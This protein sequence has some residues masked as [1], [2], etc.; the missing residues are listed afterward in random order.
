MKKLEVKTQEEFDKLPNKFDKYTQIS[1]I[2]KLE[3]ISKVFKNAFITIHDNAVIK[4]V[5]GN[6]VI[7]YVSGNAVIKSVS[8]NA[9]IKVFSSQVNIKKARQFAIIICQDCSIVQIEDKD[10]T[11]LLHKVITAPFSLEEFIN[12]Y[13]VKSKNNKLI[14]YK[15]VNSRYRDFYTGTI[16]YKIGKIIKALDWD[17]N[18]SRECGGGL[19][20]SPS[21][22]FCKKFNSGL[23][24]ECEVDIKDI[25]VCPN[26]R[27]PYKIR[28]KKLK[29]LRE[30]FE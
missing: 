9:V 16:K 6:A 25:V 24:L 17:K 7:E 18:E 14:L 27:F 30:V 2:G 5:S 4:S 11:V 20:L 28:C 3:V 8:G 19:H 21:I 22:F 26:P 29:V 15:S 23:Y 10:E 1:I 13:N 12:R